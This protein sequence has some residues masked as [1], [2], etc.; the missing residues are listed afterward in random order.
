ML[1]WHSHIAGWPGN[2]SRSWRL[3][4][5]GL[6]RWAKNSVTSCRSSLLVSIRRRRLRTR[7]AVARR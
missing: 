3:I 6:H 4:C 5:C 2:R 7:R 1:S